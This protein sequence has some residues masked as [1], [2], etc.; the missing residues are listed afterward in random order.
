M[1]PICSI[2]GLY[3][4][5]DLVVRYIGQTK[6]KPQVRLTQHMAEAVAPPG[7]TRC[8]RWVRKVL[9]SG[10]QIGIVVLEENCPW[11]EAERTWI[12][13]YR[14]EYPGILTNHSDGGCGYS[15]K[16]SEE[17]R[18]RMCWPRSEAQLERLRKHITSPEVRRKVALG[19]RGN[20]KGRGEKNGN[21]VLSDKI[22]IE[23]RNALKEGKS[24]TAI[25]KMF[26]VTKATIW[27]V[28]TGRSWKH[29]CAPT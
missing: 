8:H 12:A 2:Y 3:S 16:R 13:K 26:G 24:L 18:Q 17:T 27:K 22:V 11:N 25:G 10:Y 1:G 5:E 21:A 19:Q 9:R 6:Q 7:T 28:K 14:A 23:I 15:G 29:C 20:T 4:T